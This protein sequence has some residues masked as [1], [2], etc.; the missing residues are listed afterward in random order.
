[1][2]D[3]PET[4]YARVGG[5]HIA[6]QIFGHGPR[7]VLLLRTSF[8][9]LEL[10]WEEPNLAAFMLGLA[11]FSRVIAFDH[12]GSGVS[13]PFPRDRPF[14]DF[15]LEDAVAVMDAADA[16]R[17]VVVGCGPNY[18]AAALPAT[19]P[20]RVDALIL[21][22]AIPTWKS[23]DDFRHGLAE[24]D[25]RDR[26]FWVQNASPLV[27]EWFVRYARLSMPRGAARQLASDAAEFDLRD[28][29]PSIHVPTLIV[30]NTDS[31][32]ASAGSYLAGHIADARLVELPG[33]AIHF[34]RFDEPERVVRVVEEFVTG[35]KQAPTTNRVLATILFTDVA[36]STSQTVRVGDRRWTQTL[37]AFDEF[38]RRQVDRFG[39]RLIKSTGDGHLATFDSPGRAI[40][41]ACAMC[42][43]V[44][45]FEI[46]LRAGLHTGE[47]EKRGEDI[48]G[49][50]VSIARR[51]C[52]AGGA[53]EV[54]VSGIVPPLVAG[55]GLEFE[56]RGEHELKGVPGKWAV[57]AVRS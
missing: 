37:D 39:G 17:V 44:G 6:Y 22:N 47:I 13:D 8:N 54:L 49:L 11:S 19:H 20:E 38:T 43:G 57:Y 21:C 29:L 4:K 2:M 12:R 14:F 46:E 27:A 3:V 52:D 10:Q 18:A 15:L 9:H 56:D 55:S 42:D 45:R 24:S 7:D 50:A 53:G 36:G 26:S 32:V 23:D 33:K 48:G 40:L 51:V 31:P 41:C 35:E 28:L 30:Q 25:R 16:G 1:M 34:W 5:E